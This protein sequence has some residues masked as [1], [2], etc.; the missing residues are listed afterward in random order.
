MSL[1][2]TLVP[3]GVQHARPKTEEDE[4]VVLQHRRLFEL[5]FVVNVQK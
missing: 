1:G 5:D 4:L 3:A 2:I